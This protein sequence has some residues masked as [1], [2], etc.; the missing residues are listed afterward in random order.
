MSFDDAVKLWVYRD[1][2][3]IPTNLIQ[4]AFQDN[5]DD[6]ELLSNE[7]PVH[8]WPCAHGWMFS[9]T[10]SIDEEWI[11]NNVDLVED[12]G[13]LVYD[14]DETGILLGVDGYG[15]SFWEEHWYKLYKVRGLRWHSIEER[16]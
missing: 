7:Y 6:L 16:V 4:R 1:H 2:D 15:Y 13:F 5:P 9:P 3:C 11:R 8:C 14:S 10:N 12:A